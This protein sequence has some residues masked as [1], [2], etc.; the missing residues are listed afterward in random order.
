VILESDVDAHSTEDDI[1]PQRIPTMAVTR[2][3][4]WHKSHTVD[5]EY[6]LSTFCIYSLQEYRALQLNTTH[7]CTPFWV[8][9]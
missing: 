6:T 9:Y 1:S 2:R 7:K 5:W 8:Q 3:H 4:Y